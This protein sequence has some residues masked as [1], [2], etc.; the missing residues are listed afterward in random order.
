MII[1][2]KKEKIN[3]IYSRVYQ[4]TEEYNLQSAL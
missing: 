1:E 3:N 2:G 4:H